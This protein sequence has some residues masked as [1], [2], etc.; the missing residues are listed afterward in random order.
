MS[1]FPIDTELAR[2]EPA[3]GEFFRDGEAPLDAGLWWQLDRQGATL[4]ALRALFHGPAALARLR[5]WVFLE[6]MGLPEGRLARE[7]LNRHFHVLTDE[8]LE[9][10]LRRLR[11]ADLLSWDASEQ[12]YSVTPLAQSLL[13]LLAPL[14]A[15][16]AEHDE[17]ATLLAGVAGAQQ[18][19]T[20]QAGQLQS[21]QAQLARLNDEFA[22]A[23]ASGSEFRLRKARGRF[24]RAL[25]LVEKASEALTAIIRGAEDRNDA[26]LER[27]ARDLGLAQARLLAMASQFNRALQQ[28][29]RQRITL[30]STGITT[31]DVRRWLQQQDDLGALL[32]DACAVPVAPVF[33]A[34]HELLDA[35]EG[36]FERERARAPQAE[37]LPGARTAPPGTLDV[38]E[39]P[40]DLAALQV[41][42]QRWSA[43][44][45]T[46]R[47]L[48]PALLGSGYARAAY[49]AQLLPLMGDPQSTGLAGATG[50]LARQPWR[51]RFAAEQGPVDDP[52]VRW[53]SQ[54]RLIRTDGSPE[55]DAE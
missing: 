49:R 37:P 26:R 7:Q 22:E 18:L 28:A 36:E 8:A 51:A 50:E 39:F 43:E 14:T 9:L 5:V 25:G 11:E 29:D 20:L 15:A 2:D 17:L 41:L 6:L 35:T 47:P 24:E 32:A 19:G 45:P 16:P 21:L 27:L 55:G 23:I 1:E 40:P 33:V 38:A 42:L 12:L 52:H 34:Q 3:L 44:D 31:T 4:G 30:G 13:G 10:V 46:E 48:A 54:G 53:M